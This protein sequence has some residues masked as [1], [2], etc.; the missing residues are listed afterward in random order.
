MPRL[1]PRDL[2]IKWRTKMRYLV[3]TI[4]NRIS[5]RP[6]VNN[7]RTNNR[8]VLGAARS[9]LA[10]GHGCTPAPLAL[11]VYNAVASARVIY[12]AA[13]ASLSA[14]QLAALDADYLNA[15]REY[16]KLTHTSQVG[17]P[18]SP[19]RVKLPSPCVLQSRHSIMYCG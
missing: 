17:A 8:K 19:K 4:D 5:W 10:R 13:M 9:L 1:S 7:L 12:M 14:C 16:Y 15:V 11:G 2:H 3:V 6:A 18:R